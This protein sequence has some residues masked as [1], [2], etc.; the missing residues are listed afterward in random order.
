MA[1]KIIQTPPTSG[2][3]QIPIAPPM[4][5]SNIQSDCP[6]CGAPHYVQ[7]QGDLDMD[8]LSAIPGKISISQVQRA[9]EV[10]GPYAVLSFATGIYSPADA[11]RVVEEA[12]GALQPSP[13]PKPVEPILPALEPQI[14][15]TPAQA[16]LAQELAL[17]SLPL[18]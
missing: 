8:L 10:G 3:V 2:A 11:L 5:A 6:S 16:A 15:A 1:K 13:D 17:S 14:Q 4:T 7:V 12:I 9:P 18:G